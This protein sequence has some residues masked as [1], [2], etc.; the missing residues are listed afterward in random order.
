ELHHDDED[1]GT[2]QTFTYDLAT[3][4]GLPQ[5][6]LEGHIARQKCSSVRA[7]ITLNDVGSG[8]GTRLTAFALEL[9]G[10]RGFSKVAKAN[11]GAS[12]GGS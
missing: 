4:V 7:T 6:S 9:G 1:E 10:L 2:P 3:I 11:K 8:G 12:S 5:V